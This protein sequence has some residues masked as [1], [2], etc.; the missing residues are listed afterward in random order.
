MT[1][2]IGLLCVLLLKLCI[3]EK[4][5]L[6]GFALTRS[7]CF[8]PPPYPKNVPVPLAI[9]AQYRGTFLVP[10]PSV[11]WKKNYWYRSGGSFI[12]Q[13][14]GGTRYFCKIFCNKKN[15]KKGEVCTTT[16]SAAIVRK[17]CF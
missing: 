13:F 1:I 12:S 3:R 8:E 7:Y 4:G 6:G 10:A 11:L 2:K 16:P 5:G 9:G 17:I 15:H 14:L